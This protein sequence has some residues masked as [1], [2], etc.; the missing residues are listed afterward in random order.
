LQVLDGQRVSAGQ[1]IAT[2]NNSELVA[3]AEMDIL[4]ADLNSLRARAHLHQ[5]RLSDYRAENALAGA[6]EQAAD[7][8]RRK[9]DALKVHSPIDGVVMA[10]RLADRQGQYLK[11][12]DELCKVAQGQVEIR[13]SVP[14]RDLERFQ[15][16]IGKSVTVQLP[17]GRV[18][19]E[20]V[21]LDPM[22]SLSALDP[23]LLA[24]M[25]GPLAA[26]AN[27]TTNE[28]HSSQNAWSLSEP[29]FLAKVRV[30]NS[31]LPIGVA[32]QRAEVS[33]FAFDRTI[34]RQI[35]DFFIARF[36]Q[37]RSSQAN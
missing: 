31:A 19:G 15:S 12:G 3:K 37:A 10:R 14:Q 21:S 25:G 2:L 29:H 16:R 9:V 27:P 24:P 7:E 13:L 36:E 17:S 6:R 26:K 23:A 20:V 4:D 22:G 18:L 28:A 30:E 5:M 34:A 32:G 33:F 35:A 11:E 8:S 1:L